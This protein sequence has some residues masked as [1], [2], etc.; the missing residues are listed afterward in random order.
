MAGRVTYIFGDALT[1]K[2]SEDISMYGVD[3]Q[4][5]MNDGSF[6]GTFKLDQTGKQNS[7]LMGATTPG[8]CFIVVEREGVPFW[9]GLV[10]SRTYQAQAKSVQIYARVFE[11][12]ADR[13]FIRQNFDETDEQ[14]K[15]FTDLYTLMQNDPNSIKVGVTPYSGPTLMSKSISVRA[16]EFKTFRSVIDSLADGENGFDWTIDW[17]RSGGAYVKTLRYGFPFLGT[18]NPSTLNFEFPGNITNYWLTEAVGGAGTHIYSFGAGEGDSMVTSE[19]IHTD[20]LS[21]G[22]PRFDVGISH[23]DISVDQVLDDINNQEAAVRK[24][25]APVVVAETKGDLDPVFGSYSVGD[26]C[27]LWFQDPAHPA[28]TGWQSR[29]LGWDYKPSSED[30]TEYAKLTFQG[31]DLG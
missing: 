18:T 14:L 22:T 13:R 17:T 1:G 30:S 5:T 11:A 25:P 2:I 26:A 15:L 3:I 28:L 23:K 8:R 10:G 20:L 16:S 24:I 6:T 4:R 7:D 19:F 9:G 27:T 12:Y 21:F 29:I 31:D